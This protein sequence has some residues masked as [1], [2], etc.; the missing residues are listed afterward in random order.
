MDFID[1]LST[2]NIS[3]PT[4]EACSRMY[5]SIFEAEL[6]QNGVPTDEFIEQTMRKSFLGGSGYADYQD[7]HYEEYLNYVKQRI[8]SFQFPMR[9]FRGLYIPDGKELMLTSN[10]GEHW[11]Y[12]PTLFDR[13]NGQYGFSSSKCNVILT[14]LVTADQVKWG[15][16]IIN[17]ATDYNPNEQ[18]CSNTAE[19][20]IE[21]KRGE[22]PH[23]LE[24]QRD[25][26][27]FN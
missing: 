24:V 14:G 21:L 6:D 3:K 20:E 25:S 15:Q 1:W 8:H 27:G 18:C 12:D 16:T 26:R 19:H 4:L 13:H 11:T 23:E 9:V 2:A 5:K 17:N 7:H 22:I 10:I